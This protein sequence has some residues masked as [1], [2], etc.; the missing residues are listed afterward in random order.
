MDENTGIENREVSSDGSKEG[1]AL[2]SLDPR[3]LRNF[4]NWATFRAVIEIIFGALSCLGILTAAFGVPIVISGVRLLSAVDSLK[5]QMAFNDPQGVSEAFENLVR[6][7][8][9]RSISSVVMVI[10]TILLYVGI[11]VMVLLSLQM[12]EVPLEYY[13]DSLYY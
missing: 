7:F 12:N 4:S 11:I 3:L 13:Q 6:Y 2:I 10:V 5:R 1:A 8:K 9:L